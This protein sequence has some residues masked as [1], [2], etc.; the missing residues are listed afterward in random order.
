MGTKGCHC[1]CGRSD[2]DDFT[3]IAHVLSHSGMVMRACGR[4]LGAKA[5][6]HY[7]GIRVIVARVIVALDCSLLYGLLIL[8]G[9]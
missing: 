6:S 2:R 9:Q 3:P 1:R 5:R 7:T 8:V 4:G